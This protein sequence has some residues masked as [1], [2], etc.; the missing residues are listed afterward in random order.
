MENHHLNRS[1][2]YERTT[3]HSQVTLPEGTKLGLPNPI[4]LSHSTC[5]ELVKFQLGFHFQQCFTRVT[6]ISSKADEEPNYPHQTWLPGKSPNYLN[7]GLNGKN[8]QIK[9]D[10]FQQA[11]FNFLITG[12]YLSLTLLLKVGHQ[13]DSPNQNF[14]TKIQ[15]LKRPRK[16]ILKNGGFWS[17]FIRNSQGECIYPNFIHTH[18]IVTFFR[19]YPTNID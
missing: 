2:N 1:I 9:W 16:N 4:S 3:F 17:M 14:P 10:I 8:H 11:M 18:N 12:R 19:I 7:V 13:D 5:K 15:R 6:T